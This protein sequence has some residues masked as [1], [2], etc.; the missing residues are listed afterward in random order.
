M[1]RA[2]CWGRFSD[3][4]GIVT[5]YLAIALVVVG[6]AGAVG[7]LWYRS[8]WLAQVAA[9]TEEA[10]RHN[11]E[12]AELRARDRTAELDAV[13]RLHGAATARAADLERQL[14]RARDTAGGR[15]APAAPVLTEVM[16]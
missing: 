9:V 11:A 14:S 15:D 8:A 16:E 5:K 13:R 12:V 3:V 2:C 10:A 1:S 4:E 7:T 6:L